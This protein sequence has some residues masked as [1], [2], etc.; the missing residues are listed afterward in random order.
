MRSVRFIAIDIALAALSIICVSFVVRT[1]IHPELRYGFVETTLVCD[2]VV[3]ATCVVSYA[4]GLHVPRVFSDPRARSWRCL[5]TGAVSGGIALL[6]SH[7]VWYEAI[8]RIVLLATAA[9]I[10]VALWLTRWAAAAFLQRGPRVRTLVYGSPEHAGGFAAA[11]AGLEHSR[12]RVVGVVHPPDVVR[13]AT[14]AGSGLTRGD[15]AKLAFDGEASVLSMDVPFQLADARQL[16]ELCRA[17]AID[18][19][20]LAPDGACPLPPPIVLDELHRANVRVGSAASLWMSEAGRIPLE[21]VDD[22]WVMAALD[23]REQ[24]GRAQLIRLLD[25]ALASLGLLVFVAI[26]PFV[27][28]AQ[29]L[30]GGGDLFFVQSRT[31]RGGRA[32]RMIKFRTM[33][34]AMAQVDDPAAGEQA[35]WA[36]VDDV[37]A[38]RLGRL[39]RSHRIDELPQVINVLRGEMSMVGPRPEQPAIVEELVRSMPTYALRHLLP[40]GVTGWAQI[41]QGYVDS[42]SGTRTKLGYDLYYVARHSIWLYLDVVARTAYVALARVGAR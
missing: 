34:M 9:T 4:T 22:A 2:L 3:A 30:E 40:P 1:Q 12:C 24:P 27:W 32:F 31:G 15:R 26:V 39:L 29:R 6:V 13:S 37:R 20:T 42:V 18:L 38:T 25:V 7:F 33:A 41:H 19:L 23:R 36:R 5:V 16:S 28:L 35:L 14:E 8:G 10:A 17:A 11:I 21:F